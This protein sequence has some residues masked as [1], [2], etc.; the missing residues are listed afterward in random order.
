MFIPGAGFI[1]AIISIYDT[2]MVF[3]EKLA[4][5]IAGGEGLHRL[6]RRHRRR[7]HRRA[8]PS[9]VE[10]TLAGLLSLAISFL[11]GFVGLG[12]VTDKIMEVIKKVR[13][14]VDKAL[15]A[16]INWIVAKAKA[17]FARLFSKK[18]KKDDRTDEQKSKDKLAAIAESEGQV[19]PESFDEQVMRSKLGPIK[20][21]YKLLTL[22]MVVDSKQGESETIHFTASASDQEVGGTKQVK[23]APKSVVP[24]TLGSWIANDKG[25]FEQVTGNSTVVKKAADGKMVP[26][27]FM[28]AV[29]QG[30]G[31]TYAYADEGTK[32]NRTTFVHTSKLVVPT[33]GGQFKLK[34]EG[35]STFIREEFYKDTSSSRKQM[36][37]SKVS[38]LL[39]PANSNEFLSQG[40]PSG[41][42]AWGYT[43]KDPKSGRAI[44]PV[45]N[46]SPD[47]NP[48][49]AQH[50]NGPGSKTS[51]S[52]RE[53]WNKSPA[54]FRIMSLSLNISLGSGGVNYGQDVGL[55]FRGPGE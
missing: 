39:N 20:N 21:K 34:P 11:A 18:D 15:D 30:G 54:T 26:V 28:T 41:E 45:T 22:D 37:A 51:Q 32:W 6:D 50:W 3:V 27:N 14:S 17:L 13:A 9:R 53:S 36:T 43:K 19:D 8:P 52:S 5:I 31:G 38:G 16:A 47:H 48:P 49:I 29:P 1:P 7:Q 35:D 12:K 4:K 24:L 25:E 42:A 23:L 46:A 44:V 2:I 40:D 55:G 33:G 10:S